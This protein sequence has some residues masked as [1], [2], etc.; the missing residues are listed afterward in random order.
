MLLTKVPWPILSVKSLLLFKKLYPSITFEFMSPVILI[1]ES[2]TPTFISF[3][4]HPKFQEKS[5]LTIS[6][7]QPLLN[8]S[9]SSFD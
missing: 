3:P 5:A 7:F 2:I 9:T 4:K 8:N 6:A 1:P